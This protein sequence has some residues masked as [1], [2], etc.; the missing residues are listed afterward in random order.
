MRTYNV[1]IQVI[2]TYVVEVEAASEVDAINKS[3]A[4]PSEEVAR[5]GHLQGVETDYAEIV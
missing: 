5:I 3:Q 4:M 2:K 1:S